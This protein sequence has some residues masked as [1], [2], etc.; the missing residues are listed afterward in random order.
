M[1]TMCLDAVTAA[2]T[3]TDVIR[4]LTIWCPTMNVYLLC[5]LFIIIK[6]VRTVF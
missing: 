4:V 2:V 3:Y 5:H 1:C 6:H